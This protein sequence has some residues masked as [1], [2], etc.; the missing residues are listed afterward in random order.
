ML[1]GDIPIFAM[2]KQRMHWLSE[3]QSVLA[4]NVANS[5]T[6]HYAARDLKEL[7]FKSMLPA[8]PARLDT[9][10]TNGAH[11]QKTS[12]APMHGPGVTKTPG[13]ETTPTG[14]SVVLEEQMIKVSETQMDYEMATGLYTKSLGLL[15][16][17]L[18]NR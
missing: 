4:E 9:A 8:K 5:N 7:D 10:V 16:M 2:L 17:A 1:L 11:I 18:G 14:N 12:S 15:K 3:R 13:F 6:P